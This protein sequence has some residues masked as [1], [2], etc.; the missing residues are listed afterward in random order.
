MITLILKEYYQIFQR[1]KGLIVLGV[2]QL[3]IYWV[4]LVGRA[5]PA[6][7]ETPQSIHLTAYVLCLLLLIKFWLCLRVA[8]PKSGISDV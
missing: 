3:D 5:P 7:L 6:P 2:T 4:F 8:Q 1:A